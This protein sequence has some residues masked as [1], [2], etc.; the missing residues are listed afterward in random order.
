MH[1]DL[2]DQSIP[3]DSY[4]VVVPA[5]NCEELGYLEGNKTVVVYDFEVDKMFVVEM[6]GILA[7]KMVVVDLDLMNK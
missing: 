7:E 4:L 3:A 5:G 6:E 2:R 1:Q